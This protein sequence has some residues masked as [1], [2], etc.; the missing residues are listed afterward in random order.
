MSTAAPPVP[1]SHSTTFAL[2]DHAPS[3]N[4]DSRRV[5]N[6]EKAVDA[7]T[8]RELHDGLGQY[9]TCLRYGMKALEATATCEE[10]R[11]S[12]RQLHAVASSAQVEMRRIIHKRRPIEVEE[13][14]FYAALKRIVS[15]S[16]QVFNLNIELTLLL[17]ETLRLSEQVED[18][19]FRIVQEAIHNVVRHAGA[20]LASISLR[21]TDTHLLLR[22]RDNGCGIA[23]PGKY[24]KGYGLIGIAERVALCKGEFHL[25]VHSQGG[26]ELIVQFPLAASIGREES[27]H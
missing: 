6:S 13:V 4:D 23:E 24:R 14:G 20:T 16:T 1:L 2:N 18:H 8:A 25:G 26:T 9:L 19:C 7:H 3:Q 10:M 22:C 12:L 27:A 17:P 11:K 15:H 21:S 5:A